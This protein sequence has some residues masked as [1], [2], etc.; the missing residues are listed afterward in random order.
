V[1]PL[2]PPKHL[3]LDE[4]VHRA[5]KKKKSETGVNVKD[6]GNSALRTVLERPLLAEAIGERIISSGLLSAEQFGQLR[7]DALRDITSPIP[8]TA[9]VFQATENNT[10]VSGSWEIKELALDEERGFQIF[11]MWARDQRFNPIPV[12]THDGM[13]F[14]ITLSGAIMLTVDAESNVVTAP[15]C[16]MIPYGASH[17]TVPLTLDTLM[18]VILLPPNR[19]IP[20]WME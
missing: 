4:D 3:V 19:R 6:L 18:L 2:K 8:Q 16:Q 5:L 10:L 11:L 15:H 12:H 13:E 17:S 7:R 14:F 20:V 1:S 9:S